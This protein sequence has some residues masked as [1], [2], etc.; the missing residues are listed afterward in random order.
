ML[1]S[2]LLRSLSVEVSLGV[3]GFCRPELKLFGLVECQT[4]LV[5][6][7]IE[8]QVES[9]SFQGGSFVTTREPWPTGGCSSET[10]KGI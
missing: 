3:G 5:A 2:Y 1:T 10:L 9:A 8:F 6:F 7:K 4:S